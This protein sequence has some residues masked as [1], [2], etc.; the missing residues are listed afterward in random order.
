MSYNELVVIIG[1]ILAV[2]ATYTFG[3]VCYKQG[4]FDGRKKGHQ[5]GIED[6]R[7]EVLEENLIRARVGGGWKEWHKL[8]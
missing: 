2:T 4:E 1:I 7:I 5:A 6:G 3:W 8:T